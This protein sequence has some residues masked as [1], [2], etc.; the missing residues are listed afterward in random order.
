MTRKNVE[1]FSN[2]EYYLYDACTMGKKVLDNI[3]TSI[4][5]IIFF[6]S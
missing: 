5:L 1:K 3:Y 6:Y 2:P 4:C